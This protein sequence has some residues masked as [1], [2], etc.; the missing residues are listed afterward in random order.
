MAAVRGLPAFSSWPGRRRMAPPVQATIPS[1]GGNQ[2]MSCKT[3]LLLAG[4]AEHTLEDRVD[5]L[6]VIAEVEV[7]F[8]LGFA[9]VLPHI[10]VGFQELQEV[11]LAAPDRHGVA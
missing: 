2:P 5:V 6:E 4:C 8:D 9:Q 3:A 11:T 7:L 10:L 1:F